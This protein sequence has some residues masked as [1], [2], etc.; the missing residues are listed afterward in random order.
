MATSLS[1]ARAA[2]P[3]ARV[4]S[5]LGRLIEGLALTLLLAALVYA[6]LAQGSL[7]PWSLFGLRALVALALGLTGVAAALRGQL[8]L[9]PAGVLTALGGFLVLYALSASLSPNAFGAQEALLNTLS[10]AGGFF[11]AAALVR[12]RGRR[13]AFLVALLVG[14]LAMGV[15][16]LVQVRGYGFT[17][18]MFDPVPPISSFY[19]NRIHYAGYLDLTALAALGLT[20][21]SP[22]WWVRLTAGALALLLYLNLGL[23]YSDAGWAATGLSTLVLLVV[24]VF[25]GRG[26][27]GWV[28]GA[29]FV[30]VL[31]LG[32]GGLGAF[33]Y[34]SP[35]LS[36][37]FAQKLAALRGVTASGE[38][39]TTGLGNFYS[40]LE[41]HKNT[42][43]IIS[44]NPLNGVGPGNF[45]YAF[46]KWR[47][48]TATGSFINRQLHQL[49]NYAHNDYLQIASEAGVVAA[50]LFVLFWLAVLFGSR[51]AP[52]PLMGLYFGIVALLLHG[53][54]DGNLTINHA[55]AFLAFAAAGVLTTSKGEGA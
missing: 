32:T 28:R 39:T 7:Y 47:P 3:G 50:F 31:T 16:G 1:P 35:E 5:V 14:A 55:S 38:A 36:G 15:Y 54:V 53:L 9:P 8:R 51:R 13:N 42:L 18:T 40:R 2:A 29:A 52:V 4:G 26:R 46:P 17:P 20:L 24:W 43:R 23:T 25:Q 27:L 10:Q 37:T 45:V 33:L 19:Y 44:E 30:G 34:Y 22:V 41:I 21:F 12:G 49:V 48:P 6:P 11:L